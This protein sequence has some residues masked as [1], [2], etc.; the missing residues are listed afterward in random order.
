MMISS[1]GPRPKREER[2]V[3][4]DGREGASVLVMDDAFD[5]CLVGNFL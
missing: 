3:D 1:A 4:V 2:A 5:G